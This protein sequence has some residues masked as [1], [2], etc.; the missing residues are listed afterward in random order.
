MVRIGVEKELLNWWK[1]REV[2]S[3]FAWIKNC[4]YVVNYLYLNKMV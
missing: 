4:T 2:A 3:F 1:A